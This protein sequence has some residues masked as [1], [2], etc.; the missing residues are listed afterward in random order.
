M[1]LLKYFPINIDQNQPINTTFKKILPFQIFYV[2][3]SNKIYFLIWNFNEPKSYAPQY[4][5]NRKLQK[6]A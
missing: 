6:I 3:S 5:T 2:L 4:E 1:R